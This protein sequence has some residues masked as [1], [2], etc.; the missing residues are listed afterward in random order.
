M[1]KDY[2]LLRTDL[3][4]MAGL[5]KNFSKKYVFIFFLYTFLKTRKANNIIE[6][7][8][9]IIMYSQHLH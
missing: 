7:N 2:W 9:V 3:L 1:D 5:T 4:L 8:Y 6:R